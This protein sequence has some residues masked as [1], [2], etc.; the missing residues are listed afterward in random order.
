MVRIEILRGKE[1]DNMETTIKYKIGRDV[2]TGLFIAVKA[3]KKRPS[4][5]VVET[6]TKILKVI[7]K[8]QT[9]N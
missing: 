1:C 6:I 8:R 2:K 7:R 4:T 3:A 5:T 9:K